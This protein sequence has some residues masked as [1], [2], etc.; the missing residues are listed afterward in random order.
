MS[1]NREKLE[2]RIANDLEYEKIYRL[3]VARYLILNG[4]EELIPARMKEEALK[5][6]KEGK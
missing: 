3:K 2:H 6:K 5:Y 4:V 1:A